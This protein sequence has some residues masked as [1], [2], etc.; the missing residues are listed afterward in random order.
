RAVAA[1]PEVGG[2]ERLKVLGPGFLAGAAP[3]GRDRVA[4]EEDVYAALLGRGNILLVRLD[5]ARLWLVFLVDFR[6]RRRG[7]GF[8]GV[9]RA[10]SGATAEKQAGNDKEVGKTEGRSHGALL[11][12]KVTG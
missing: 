10:Q 9:V 12:G 11:G 4:Q 1:D 7:G 3:A 8:L 6:R 5:E 2:L